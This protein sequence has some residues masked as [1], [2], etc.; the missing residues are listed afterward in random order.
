MSRLL[1]VNAPSC[2][3]ELSKLPSFSKDFNTSHMMLLQF[4]ECG[5]L[6]LY[7]LVRDWWCIQNSINLFAVSGSVLC[8][9]Q[10][11]YKCLDFKQAAP[12]Y[13]EVSSMPTAPSF[14]CLQAGSLKSLWSSKL[15]FGI[16]S[17]TAPETAVCDWSWKLLWVWLYCNPLGAPCAF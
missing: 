1:N 9:V 3:K 8:F 14:C 6:P 11:C 4:F 2:S 10:L 15:L 16:N 12:G 5:L 13:F 17:S 7:V